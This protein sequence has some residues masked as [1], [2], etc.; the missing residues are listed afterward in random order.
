MSIFEDK[1]K[2]GLISSELKNRHNVKTNCTY[3]SAVISGLKQ[4]EKY[5][6]YEDNYYRLQE[7][8]SLENELGIDLFTFVEVL[9]A[10]EIYFKR[11]NEI[12]EVPHCDILWDIVAN[13]IAIV[14]EEDKNHTLYSIYHLKDY[15]K[16]WALTKEELE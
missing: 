7:Y 14:L 12:L 2:I 4:E 3:F 1:Q 6:V 9:K 8:K 15:G 13:S 11:E 10:P 5:L 16:T